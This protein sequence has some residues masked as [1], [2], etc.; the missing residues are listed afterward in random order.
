MKKITFFFLLCTFNAFAQFVVNTPYTDYGDHFLYN[1]N[2]YFA[3]N[4]SNAFTFS[5][6]NGTIA[7]PIPNPSGVVGTYLGNPITYNSK[8]YFKFGSNFLGKYDGTAVSIIDKVNPSDY[9]VISPAVI[10]N[11]KLNY[12]YRNAA[13]LRQLA[14]YDGTTQVVYPNPDASTSAFSYVF[15]QYNGEQYFGYINA[16]GNTALAKFNGTNVSLISNANA[17]DVGIYSGNTCVVNNV[18]IFLYQTSDGKN[19]FAKYDGTNIT[20]VPNLSPTDDCIYSNLIAYDN[21]VY[22]RYRNGATGKFHLAKY[23]GTTLTMIP[24]SNATD[25]GY[26][27]SPFVYNNKLYIR[28]VSASSANNLARTAG[29]TLEVLPNKYLGGGSDN[30]SEYALEIGGNIYFRTETALGYT[31]LGKFDGT[32]LTTYGNATNTNPLLGP[33]NLVFFNNKIH[34]VANNGTNDKLSYLDQVILSN[35]SFGKNEFQLYPNP[36]NGEFTI[37]ITQDMIGEKAAIYNLLG[38]KIKSFELSELETK[39]SIDKGFYI[40][41]IEKEGKKAIQKIKIN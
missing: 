36:S 19:H 7:T 13:Y 28:Y 6:Y 2:L 20:V 29:A 10:Y 23:D 32:T 5:E 22:A 18:L 33:N 41:V 24:N 1:G 25:N 37:Q 38:Q 26:I 4:S 16:S 14:T 9:G 35:E 27:D 15:S 31:T 3:N 40:I 30:P 12:I 34:F 8:F 39:Q 21:A 17:L 11:S